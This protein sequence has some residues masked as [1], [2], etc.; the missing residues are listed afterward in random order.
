MSKNI[1]SIVGTFL[2]GGL[3][4]AAQQ[5]FSDRSAKDA[6]EEA[7]KKHFEKDNEDNNSSKT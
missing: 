2:I 1:V 6:A 5:F 3:M 7:V 4:A